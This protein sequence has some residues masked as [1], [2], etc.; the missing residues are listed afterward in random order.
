MRGV[1]GL[2]PLGDNRGL[3]VAEAAAAAAE[4]EGRLVGLDDLADAIRGADVT[5]VASGAC[6]DDPILDDTVK[7]T[8]VVIAADGAASLL[9]ARG[10][11]PDIIVTDFD[12]G[13][14]PL[15]RCKDSI[16]VAHFHGDNAWIALDWS[17]RLG[18][19][20]CTVQQPWSIRCAYTPGFTDGD[21][22]LVLAALLGARS[23]YVVGWCPQAPQ[24]PETKPW[25]LASMQAKRVKLRAAE[26]YYQ[27]V[28]LLCRERLHCRIY[29]VGSDGRWELA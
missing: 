4:A 28:S 29:T 9:L 8:E 26:Y 6:I 12:G 18:K 25:Y 13:F 1:L 10:T 27:L 20:L 19:L 17:Y 5:L 11:C 23:I 14:Y 21:R 2:D 3:L 7:R 22:A 15:T 24:H 16:V